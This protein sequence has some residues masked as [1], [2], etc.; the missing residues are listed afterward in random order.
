MN[1]RRFSASWGVIAPDVHEVGEHLLVRRA[2]GMPHERGVDA[3][4]RQPPPRR[5]HRDRA[6][7]GLAGGATVGRDRQ[8]RPVVQLDEQV[9]LLVGRRGERVAQVRE[10]FADQALGGVD[11]QDAGLEPPAAIDEVGLL[12]GVLEV[13]A[14]ERLVRDRVNEVGGAHRQVR[15]DVDPRAQAAVVPVV[16]ATRAG[17]CTRPTLRSSPSRHAEQRVGPGPEPLDEPLDDRRQAID[18]DLEPLVPGGEPVG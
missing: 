1:S 16:A 14:R 18:R 13:V 6:L 3:N 10:A 2:V 11:E 5:T 9:G 17:S 15:V 12:P 7:G 4:R 8:A